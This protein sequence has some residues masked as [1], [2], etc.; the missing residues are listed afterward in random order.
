LWPENMKATPEVGVLLRAGAHE[1][2]DGEASF[3]GSAMRGMG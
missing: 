2:S 3:A 1:P